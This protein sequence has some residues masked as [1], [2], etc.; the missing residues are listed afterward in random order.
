MLRRLVDLRSVNVDAQIVEELGE[1]PEDEEVAHQVD[2]VAKHDHVLP[3]CE[4]VGLKQ[5]IVSLTH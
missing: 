4:R 3:G 1:P 2:Q 5:P